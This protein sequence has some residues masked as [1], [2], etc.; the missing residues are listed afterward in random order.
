MK[1]KNRPVDKGR[2]KFLSGAAAAGIG[3]VAAAI[4]AANTLAATGD[5]DQ[6]PKKSKGYQLSQHVL[7]YYKSAAS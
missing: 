2:R 4:P 3:G 5:E 1:Q 7:D 6:S